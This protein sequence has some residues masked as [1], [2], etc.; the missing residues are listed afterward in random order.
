MKHNSHDR[1]EILFASPGYFFFFDHKQQIVSILPWKLL[2]PKKLLAQ[3]LVNLQDS[4]G[5][6][7]AAVLVWMLMENKE[8]KTH[9]PLAD[10]HT[11]QTQSQALQTWNMSVSKR[12]ALLPAGA[13]K[14]LSLSFIRHLSTSRTGRSTLLFLKDCVASLS[15]FSSWYVR[16]RCF[17]W[18]GLVLSSVRRYFDF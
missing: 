17:I 8:D 18:G 3:W 2:D 5:G 16:D 12:G 7:A 13:D 4:W 6:Q 15:V 9:P 1:S 14:I 11:T 10:L